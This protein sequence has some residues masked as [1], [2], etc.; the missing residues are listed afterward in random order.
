MTSVYQPSP[1]LPEKRLKIA[2]LIRQFVTT[3]GA[4]KYAVEVTRRMARE[5][6]IHVFAQE[7]IFNGDE[8]I[9][10][11]KIPRFFTRPSFLNQLLFSYFTRRFLDSSFDIIHSH[12]RACHFDVL[13]VHC[14]C[15]R[16]FITI[17]KSF[18][19]RS[20]IWLS[21]ALSPRKLSYLWLEKKQFTYKEGRF[22]IAVSEMVK[23]NVQ[24]NY[25]LPDECFGIAYPGV[26]SSLTIRADSHQ[27]EKSLRSEF[28]IGYDDLVILFVG[29]EFKRK[30]LDGLLEGFA[31]IRR[32]GMKLIVAGG[33][34]KKSHY[35]RKVKRL[36]IENEVLFLGLVENIED[37]YSVA[38]I[39]ILPTLSEPAGMAPLEAMLCGIPT[40]LSCSRFA[41]IA[42]CIKNGEAIILERPDNAGEIADSLR[43]LMN[44]GLRNELGRKGH[45]L[46]EKLTWENT[47]KETLAMYY[48]VLE[49]K[50]GR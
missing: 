20:V 11:H 45:Q 46:A 7:W 43:R 33:G 28:G 25:P 30:G 32:S 27:G 5:H 8:H 1:M 19:R 38:D 34:E 10:F 31:L 37:V 26:D 17:Q 48:K 41:G 14:P 2:I 15:F 3:G 4:E 6:D 18:W 39:Y 22:F 23:K 24:A 35:A 42:E 13:T 16:T 47:T 50:S 44:R 21:V 12:E 29:T 40:V 49:A 36:G 9:T